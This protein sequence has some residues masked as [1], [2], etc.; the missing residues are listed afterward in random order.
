L[1]SARPLI[2]GGYEFSAITAVVVGGV[3]IVGGFGSVPRAIAGLIFVQLLTN[4][5]VLDGVRTPIQG[6]VLGILIVG[7]VGM[8]AA[9]RKRGVA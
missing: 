1:Q 5:M 7:A 2:G 6:F 4:V 8:D 3:S 9:L